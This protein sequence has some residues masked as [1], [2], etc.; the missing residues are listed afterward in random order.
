ME[1]IAGTFDFTNQINTSDRAVSTTNIDFCLMS[2]ES[3]VTFSFDSSKS[4]SNVTGTSV[5]IAPD[6]VTYVVGSNEDQTVTENVSLDLYTWY[7]MTVKIANRTSPMSVQISDIASGESKY[8]NDDIVLR[9]AGDLLYRRVNISSNGLSYL[10]NI[11]VYNSEITYKYMVDNS[12][13]AQVKAVEGLAPT[14][15]ENNPEKDGF[16]FKEWVADEEDATVFNAVFEQVTPP[17]PVLPTASVSK[18][19]ESTT[20]EGNAAV[21]YMATFE[22]DS[23][24][25]VKGITWTVTKNGDDAQTA[26]VSTDLSGETTIQTDGSIVFGLVID[27]GNSGIGTIG[28]VTAELK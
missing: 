22:S 23:A 2:A 21:S 13:Y 27:A 7:R 25:T 26:T 1:A 12:E 5:K 3:N 28:T 10:A 4:G 17:E 18:V 20:L 14:P 9:N 24:F 8:S 19:A 15:P 6:G 16:T 11:E